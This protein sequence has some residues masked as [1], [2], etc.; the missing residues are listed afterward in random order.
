MKRVRYI[1]NR[2]E[3]GVLAMTLLGLALMAFVE[4]VLRYLFNHSF[5]W[6]EEFSR[7]TSVFITFMGAS[8]GVKYGLHFSMDFFVEKAGNR[9]G[10]LMR[11][12]SDLL[13][14]TLFAAIA[15]LS[16]QHANKLLL[17]EVTSGAMQVPMF[18]PYL[19]IPVFS[20]VI[21]LRFLHQ[22]RRHLMGMINN[23]RVPNLTP[24]RIG[25]GG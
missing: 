21:S 12:G 2:L 1:L 3:E 25:E 20:L 6:F 8:L 18:W 22:A 24:P 16:W 23:Q 15:W 4:V 13:S 19:P 5:T 11:V 9:A 14:A 17:R 7:F 10:N